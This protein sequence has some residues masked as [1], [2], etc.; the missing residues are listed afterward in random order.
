MNSG[1]TEVYF[2]KFEMNFKSF[3]VLYKMNAYRMFY[4]SCLKIISTFQI[5]LLHINS[6]V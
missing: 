3:K 5:L 6:N 1:I 4:S 2:V